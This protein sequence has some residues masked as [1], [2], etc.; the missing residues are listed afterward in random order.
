MRKE[1]IVPLFLSGLILGGIMVISPRATT[2]INEASTEIYGIDI[3]CLT[4][5][6]KDLPV[7]QFPTH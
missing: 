5:N 7:Q 2:I 3:M 4:K 6:A 1:V